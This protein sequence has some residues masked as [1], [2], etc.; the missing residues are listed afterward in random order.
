[1]GS[2]VIEED[3]WRLRKAASLVKLLALS[4]DH[5][6]HREQVMNLLWPDLDTKA[7][8]NNF[9]YALHVARNALEP[10]SA[11]SRYLRLGEG[12]L[13]LCPDGSIWVD[14]EAFEEAAKAARRAHD[15]AAYRAAIELYAGD[16]LPR[17]RYESWTEERRAEL[18]TLQLALIV[19]MA[20]LYEERGEREAAIEALGRVVAIES[21]H[22]EAR[23]ELMRLDAASG[24]RGEALRQY[25]KLK[26]ALNE[27]FDEEPSATSRRLYEQIKAGRAPERPE[28][29]A[30]PE[31]Q[32]DARHNLPAQRTSFVGREQE[33]VEVKRMFSMTRL[34]TL[35]GAGGAGKTRLALEAAR[36]LAGLYPNGAWLAELA[37]LSDPALVT[38]AVARALGVREQPNQ[39][40]TDTLV[41]ALRKQK[42]L[43]VL[44]NCEHLID[45]AA[46]LAETLLNSC[47]R[48]R[49]LATSRE[50]LGVAGEVVWQVP[51]LSLPEARRAL[52]PE[53]LSGFESARL[54]VER[55][56]YRPPA[57]VLSPH[58]AGAVAE[59][60]RQ[61][62]GMPLAIELAAARVGTLAV[63]QISERLGDSLKLL[64]G[65]GRT[66]TPRQQT[67]RGALD[68]SYDLLDEEERGLFERLSVFVGGW[69]LEAA[70]AVG[71]EPGVEGGIGEGDVLDL[72]SRLVDKSLVIAEAK[73]GGL[74]YRFLEPVRQYGRE[75]LDAA[76]GTTGARMAPVLAPVLAARLEESEATLRR[77]AGF[78]VALA[79]EAGLGLKGLR[80][81]AW[82]KRLETEL[83]NLRA[84]E[85]WL[86]D[87]GEVE[88][89]V[90]LTWALWFFWVLHGHQNEVRR[91]TEEVLAK[92][93]VLPGDIRA[94]AL[95][96]RATM[97]YGLESPEQA[98]RLLEESAALFRRAG[99]RP[100]LALALGGAG[101]AGLR[102]DA[103]R[104]VSRLEES[105]GIFRE[106]GDKWG[107]SIAFAYLGIV[108]LHTGD[109]AESARCFEEA[110][111]LSREVG[112]RYSGYISLYNWALVAQAEGDHARAKE[113][114]VEGLGLSVEVS[115]R[116]NTAY[117][118]EG[119]ARIAVLQGEPER[120]VRLFG[121]SEALLEPIG[122]PLYAHAHDRAPYE[123]AVNSLRTGLG[124]TDFAAM[125]AEGRAMTLER[126]VGYALG[127]E[128]PTPAPSRKPKEPRPDRQPSILTRRER[129]V[130]LLVARGLTNRRIAA[131]LS[132]SEN[133]AAN[134]VARIRKKLELPSR[135]QI[136]VWVTEQELHRTD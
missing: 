23:A 87:N 51:P 27:E 3:G 20:R 11:S 80:Q 29:P 63:E 79:E 57:F 60:C 35:T 38:Q 116:A 132:I 26:E 53:D 54:F 12:Q 124:E 33:L 128:E 17:D 42:A 30:P 9:H 93:N 69:T 7:A 49:L 68:W 19:E 75:K 115:D 47:P 104:A 39:P 123:Q 112:N 46:R 14:V 99:D 50:A 77:H 131:E 56:L 72:L 105:L 40:L 10:S 8:T 135:S 64:T 91:W 65:G 122:A 37:P 58:N 136:A 78:F 88:D 100:N 82:L 24:R 44:D 45:A 127:A 113:L 1:V 84:A 28:G 129:E 134:H 22:E 41:N 114:Y 125:W 61:L 13:L 31:E 109:P 32:P 117:C 16:L 111:T 5:R 126:A 36:D 34:L 95:G 108:H 83:G 90:R 102:L 66:T 85:T 73:E 106:L 2:Q 94:K 52:T 15:P 110:L 101:I 71:A 70:E 92:S 121:A 43:L 55:A 119:L 76:T 97:S 89:A 74:R 133:T 96:L 62:D 130:A 6:M 67:L 4:P 25:E 48:L 18:R 103:G 86:L 120:A 107:A 98:T 81:V 118:L 59:I 21:M